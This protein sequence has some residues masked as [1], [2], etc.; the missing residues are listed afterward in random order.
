MLSDYESTVTSEAQ[1]AANVEVENKETAPD[2]KEE[3]EQQAPTEKPEDAANDNVNDDGN[4]DDG[5]SVSSTRSEDSDA[6]FSPSEDPE[7]LLIKATSFKEEGN[8]HFKAKDYEKASRSYRHG[9][10]TLKPLNRKNTGDDQ[11]KAL[12]ISLQTNLSMMCFKLD[13]HK[14]SAQV[15]TAVL[16]IDSKN[17]KALYRRAVARRKLGDSEEARN[18]LREALKYDP[19]NN[20]MKKELASLKKDIDNAV[21]AQKKSL[22]KAFSKGGGLLFDDKGKEKQRKE[23]DAKLKKK[24]EEQVL[25]K[26]KVEWEDECVK[27]MAKG[28]PAVSFEEWENEHKEKEEAL[29]KQKA[30]EEKRRKEE[31]RKARETAKAAAK[32]EESDSDD[33]LTERELAQLRGYKK[34][35]DGRTTSYFSREQSFHEKNLIGDIT[36]QRLEPANDSSGPTPTG[37][38]SSVN[39]G[40][41]NPSAWNQAGTWEEKDT[42][43]WCRDSLNSRL[44]ETKVEAGSLIVIV[45]EVKDL[46]GDASVAIVSGRTRYIFDFHCELSFEVR[47]PNTDDVIASGS[48]QLPDICSTHHEELEVFDGGWKKPPTSEQEEVARDCRLGLISEVRESVKL[49]VE[50]FNKKY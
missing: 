1:A 15:A 13:K 16:K 45:A 47:D 33:E 32:A 19:S 41:G 30:E 17:V 10:N 3:K 4:D 36:P 11:V 7:I 12:L 18:D 22:Q 39:G 48:L 50:D 28:E 8:T 35:S 25:K 27:R 31:K 23:E 44:K 49:W 20:A 5:N 37:P 29:K 46:A 9:T 40:K 34:T 42:T 21:K 6:D 2:Q 38:A 24:Q 26:R 43:E 14:Q